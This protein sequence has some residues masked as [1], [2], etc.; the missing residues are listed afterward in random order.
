MLKQILFIKHQHITYFF[1][2]YISVKYNKVYY[3]LYNFCI[4]LIENI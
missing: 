4:K 3:I 1:I 2:I